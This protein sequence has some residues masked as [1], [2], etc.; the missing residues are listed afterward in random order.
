MTQSSTHISKRS[1]CGWLLRFSLLTLLAVQSCSELVVAQELDAEGIEFFESRIRPVLVEH[2]YQCHSPEMKAPKGE[3][4]VDSRD[5]L[6]QGG[7]SG[8]AVVPG[9]AEESL[10]LSALKYEMFEM[11]PAGKLG[12]QII[13]DFQTWIEMGAPDP[14]GEPTPRSSTRPPLDIES[15]QKFWAFQP[16]LAPNVPQVDDKWA[17]NDIDRLLL[18]AQHEAH[19]AHVA[20]AEPAQLLRRVYFD[21]IGL[22]PSPDE[23]SAFVRAPTQEAYQ[24]V[25]DRLLESSH[26]GERWG[27]HWLDIVRYA[28]STGKTRNFPFPFAWRYRDYVIE[29]LNADV[30]YDR[31]LKEQIAG[32][33]LPA[34]TAAERERQLVATGFLALGAV[35]LNERNRETYRMDV[36]GDQIDVLCRSVMGL[37]VGCARCHD[38]K[39]DPIPTRDYYALAGIFRSTDT[40]NG[41]LPQ[42]RNNYGADGSR[43]LKL[44][45]D[46]ED[47]RV[48]MQDDEPA[49]A[50]VDPVEWRRLRQRV[51]NERQ[52]L[53]ALEEQVVQAN[54]AGGERRTEP[55][56]RRLVQQR[57]LVQRLQRDLQAMR[58]KMEAT[59]EA[60]QM[61]DT[62]SQKL[63]GPLAMGVR[64]LRRIG[65]SP[66]YEGG[67]IERPADSVPRGF[68]QVVHVDQSVVPT[69]AQSGRLE[70]AEWLTQPDHPL[71]SR[72]MVNRMWHHLFGRGIVETVDNFGVMGSRPDHPEL[73]DYLAVRFVADGW[74]VKRLIRAMVTSHAYQQSGTYV[75]TNA[76][77]DGDNRL[78]WRM[79]PR[80]LEAEAIRDAVL[81][82][83][84]QLELDPPR[85]SPMQDVPLVQLRRRSPLDEAAGRSPYR[86]IYLP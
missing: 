27:R 60:A 74:S 9:R 80:R 26:F 17:Y 15:G 77:I 81:Y 16:L 32:D 48:A 56:R 71:T 55:E 65:D 62:G 20:D 37:T 10:I 12:D 42:R 41:Y 38:H 6:R 69:S 51:N 78:I 36:V 59:V 70:L 19:V 75:E 8:H 14:R 73:L 5:L 57:Q 1:V 72:V 64:D 52:T 4:R 79:P 76:S 34:A 2:C 83:S 7:E 43:Y 35:D 85:G 44:P 23:I 28:E 68:L 47:F 82:M 66:L 61:Q 45:V 49:G 50:E 67:D 63:T 58:R 46:G 31:F 53:R 40:L 21:L 84:G 22:P 29:S 33:L 13:E 25:V 39:F 11:P 18:A 86:S 24:A 30:P 54:S 3:L